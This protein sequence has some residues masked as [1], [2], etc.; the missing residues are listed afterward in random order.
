MTRIPSQKSSVTGSEAA[1]D[2]EA[3]A[4]APML[5]PAHPHQRRGRS[6][7]GTRAIAFPGLIEAGSRGRP[8]MDP[9]VQ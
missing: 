9:T 2:P 8:W 3:V 7:S 4:A 6:G 1:F 5:G